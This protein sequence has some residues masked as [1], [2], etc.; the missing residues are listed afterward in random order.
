ME[1]K[2]INKI[3]EAAPVQIEEIQVENIQAFWDIH[4]PYLVD[5]GIITD[6]EDK[7]YFQS[8]EYRDTLK[9]HMLRPQDRHHMIYF[10]RG[11][12]RIGAA[13]YTTYQ[14]EDGKCFILDYW[15]FP[16]FRGNGT[17][18]RCFEALEQYTK[19]DGAVYYELNCTRENAMRF[20]KSLGF[21]ENGVDEY[22]MALMIRR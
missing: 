14:S 8:E 5:N 2:T 16:E 6:D 20:W 21:T 4:F 13:Q 10:V 1:I 18:H 22:G 7:Q 11:G 17:G 19:A 15:V 3:T 12:V 9:A